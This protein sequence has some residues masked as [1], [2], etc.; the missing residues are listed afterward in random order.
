MAPS[1]AGAQALAALDKALAER[2]HKDGHAFRRATEHLC[3]FRQEVIEALESDRAAPGGRERLERVNSII[4]VALAGNFPLGD[5]PWQEIEKARG[6]LAS[7]LSE[8][9]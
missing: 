8:S 9:T 5:V 4:S 1:V 7:I 3:V 6:W 2:P